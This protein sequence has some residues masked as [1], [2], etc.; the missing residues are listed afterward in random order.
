MKKTYLT[1]EVQTM[2]VRT[3]TMIAA[4]GGTI[5]SDLLTDVTYGGVDENGE[6]E[7]SARRGSIWDDDEE[8]EE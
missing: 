1:P 5:N 6:M 8:E 4:S 7:P 3:I 2:H